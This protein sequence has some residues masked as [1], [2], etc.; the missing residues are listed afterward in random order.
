[1]RHPL[2]ASLLAVATAWGDDGFS[3][4]EPR[5]ILIAPPPHAAETL[6]EARFEPWKRETRNEGAFAAERWQQDFLLT[7]RL[8]VDEAFTIRQEIRSGVQSE[9][10]LGQELATTYRDALSLL[11][12]TSAELRAGA[13]RLAAFAQQQWIAN[14]SVPFSEIVT[15]GTEAA[16]TAMRHLTLKLQAEW[17]QREEFAASTFADEQYRLLLDYEWIPKRFRTTAG[18]A[19]A[20]SVNE[21]SELPENS[22]RKLEAGLRWTP[23]E[24]TALTLGAEL[25]A[26]D[27]LA[28]E[29]ET[30]AYAVKLQQQ[31]LPSARLELQAGYE[32]KGQVALGSRQGLWN[33][34][35]NSDFTLSSD[36]AAGLGIRYRHHQQSPL[37]PPAEELSLSLSLKGSF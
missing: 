7:A 31:L 9:T 15:Y 32:E 37:R 5:Q 35:A 2:V 1:M 12:K 6:V 14:N 13:L 3:L 18:I 4:I 19:L 10:I 33:L 26:H 27:T 34:G 30:E 17:R 23:F 36:W 20:H 28:A 25:A 24:R 21:S 11:E 8:P 29:T 22:Q 16:I